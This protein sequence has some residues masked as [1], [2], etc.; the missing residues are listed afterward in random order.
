MIKNFTF[1][2]PTKIIFGKGSISALKREIPLD[3]R[4]LII[5]GNSS[6]KKYGIYDQ[7][8]KALANRK[9]VFEFSGI[10]SNPEYEHLLKCVEFVK[11]NKIDYL[12]AAGG[13][14]V[15]DAAK[16][17]SLASLYKGDAWKIVE[18]F[19]ACC[20]E[21]LPVATIVTCPGSGSELNRDAVISRASKKAKLPLG[22]LAIYPKFAIL[23][24]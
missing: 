2:S 4:I 19:G 1:Q 13:G 10:R 5:Y 11:E 6:L 9:E 12:L 23:D 14:S 22:K 18:S 3:K 7:I 24:P 16:F 17:V 21:A 20:K 8:K 15:M